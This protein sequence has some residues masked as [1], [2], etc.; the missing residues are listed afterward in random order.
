MDDISEEKAMMRGS[1][2]PSTT[3]QTLAPELLAEIFLHCGF[4]HP[5]QSS[6]RNCSQGPLLLGRVCSLWRTISVSSSKLWSRFAISG[7]RM[8]G[9]DCN[10]GLQ[11]I[12][13]WISRSGSQLLSIY[14][15]YDHDGNHH[16]EEFIHQAFQLIAAQSWR[17][18]DI[19]MTIPS[20]FEGTMLAPFQTGCLPQLE[21]FDSTITDK[22]NSEYFRSIDLPAAPRLQIFRHYPDRGT[23]VHLEFGG[24]MHHLKSLYISFPLCPQPPGMSLG[25][26]LAC[27]AHCPLLEE[28]TFTI[29][30]DSQ[31]RPQ[32]IPSII[33]HSHLREFSLLLDRRFNPGYVFDTLVLPALVKLHLVMERDRY[34]DYTDWPYLKSMLARSRPQLQRLRLDNVGMSEATLIECLAYVPSLTSLSLCDSHCTDALLDVLTMDENDPSRSMCPCLETIEI[35]SAS[36]FSSG[37]M[38]NMILSRRPSMNDTGMGHRKVL[39]CVDCRDSDMGSIAFHPEIV[40]CVSDGLELYSPD[41]FE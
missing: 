39:Q 6:I 12:N 25:D 17:W 18:K 16:D 24:Q 33:K 31:G 34:R 40:K 22:I 3:I 20:R 7:Y 21:S 13:L 37:A 14:I 38:I 4:P 2:V 15:H 26:V 8:S 41:P 9:I 28:L 19:T 36:H 27:L 5:Y 35:L 23:G 11:V 29:N 1:G 32:E 10:K 30:R